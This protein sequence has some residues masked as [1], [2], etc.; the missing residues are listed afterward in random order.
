MRRSRAKRPAK[1]CAG[2]L[3]AVIGLTLALSVTAPASAETDGYESLRTAAVPELSAPWPKQASLTGPTGE[4]IR[5]PSHSPFTLDDVGA[6]PEDDPPT[7]AI[8]TLFLPPDASPEAPVPAVVLLHGASGVQ[9]VRELTYGRQ[10]AAQGVA[11]LV[12]DAFGARRDR[13]TRFI[14]RLIEITEAMLLADAYAALDYLASRPEIDGARVALIGFSYGGMAATYAAYAQVAEVYAPGGRRFAGHVAFY[15]PC[16]AEFEDTRA[17]GAPLLMLYGT[18]DA[19]VDPER[20]AEVANRLERGGTRVDMIAYP[21]AYHQWDGR[22]GTPR[23]IGRN[24]ADCH[25]VVEDDGSVYDA[26]WLLPMAGPLTRKIIL[27]LCS[28]SEGY[29]IGRDDSVRARSNRDMGRFLE[30]VF[31]AP[32]A[33]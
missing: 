24:L 17:T 21:G 2:A 23:M 27:G 32:A 33:G 5:F 15:A 6:G 28:A 11:A 13:A 1:R 12:V 4:R 25:L 19:I 9:S 22:F 30:R 8:G 7:E 14:D 16:I 3:A 18:G 31:A 20:C 10:F 26:H 29:M